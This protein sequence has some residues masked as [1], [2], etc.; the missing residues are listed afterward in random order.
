MPLIDGWITQAAALSYLVSCTITSSL[1][2]CPFPARLIH[3]HKTCTT[4]TYPSLS[5]AVKH[6][7]ISKSVVIST[8]LQELDDDDSDDLVV[9]GC[10]IAVIVLRTVVVSKESP[11]V[12]LLTAPF[13]FSSC[14]DA[15]IYRIN[16]RQTVVPLRSV[17]NDDQ[18]RVVTDC[19]SDCHGMEV[20]SRC[21]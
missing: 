16:N 13:I 14:K 20:A 21:I 7:S 6:A 5:K 17:A 9:D 3:I 18:Y 15:S 2:L 1:S 11:N 10:R 19:G 4:C 12:V 8:E